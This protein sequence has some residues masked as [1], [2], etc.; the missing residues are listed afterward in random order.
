MNAPEE[1]DV[2]HIYHPP[3]KENKYDNRKSNLRIANNQENTRN[4]H[5]SIA[6]KSGVTGVRYDENKR[7]WC[8][9]I[10]HNMKHIHLGYFD[11]F[12]DAVKIRKEAEK[13][14]FKDWRIKNE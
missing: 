12:E 14:Y 8:A 9:Y 5:I 7:K 3:R 10:G 2:D 11:D 13:K 1:L 6:N 4:H